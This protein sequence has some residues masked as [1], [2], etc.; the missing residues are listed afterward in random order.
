LNDQKD[1]TEWA[2]G[3]DF[4]GVPVLLYKGWGKNGLNQ[5]HFTKLAG[6]FFCLQAK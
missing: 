1:V 2:E 5:I 3:W 4:E 6:Y